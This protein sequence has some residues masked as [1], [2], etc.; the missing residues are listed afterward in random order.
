MFSSLTYSAYIRW[1]FRLSGFKTL[2]SVDVHSNTM[3]LSTFS[4]YLITAPRSDPLFNPLR[5]QIDL[6]FF[7]DSTRVS[8]PIVR[9]SRRKQTQ[10]LLFTTCKVY[11]RVCSLDFARLQEK[12]CIQTCCCEGFSHNFVYACTE[13]SSSVVG[14]AFILPF[15]AR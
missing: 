2:S 14:Q 9:K 10:C 13:N 8:L 7:T 4:V 5:L 6:L 15:K 11:L 3:L 1:T 12:S